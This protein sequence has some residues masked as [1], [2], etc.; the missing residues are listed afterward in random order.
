MSV[1]FRGSVE[2]LFQLA[3]AIV[4]VAQPM[5]KYTSRIPRDMT[6]NMS[7]MKLPRSTMSGLEKTSRTLPRRRAWPG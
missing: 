6:K 4:F 1:S 2:I 3:C 7:A 5:T